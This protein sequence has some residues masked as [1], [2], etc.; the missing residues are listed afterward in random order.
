MIRFL[1]STQYK[2]KRHMKRNYNKL[3]CKLIG[4]NQLEEATYL[5][6]AHLEVRKGD[7]TM[8]LAFCVACEKG[9]L[10]FAQWLYEIK[11]TRD[12]SKLTY[13]EAFRWSCMNGD[14]LAAQWL[15]Q[16]R[17]ALNEYGNENIFNNICAY[18][19][20]QV[21]QWMYQIK[22]TI[23]IS[24]DNEQAFR[25][26]CLYGHLQ[27]AQWLLDIQPTLDISADDDDAFRIAYYDGQLHIA[28]WLQS[29]CPDRYLLTIENHKMTHY[30]IMKPLQYFDETVSFKEEDNVC[31][32]CTV[33]CVAVQTA[34]KHSYC[35]ECLTNW[36]SSSHSNFACPYCREKIEKVFRIV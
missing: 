11:P 22:P 19:H 30:Q 25:S 17:P 12:F 24:A 7:T 36:L 32:I 26:A 33:N 21:A 4:W 1:Q 10:E 5:L 23:D 15:C 14:L 35:K 29:I 9:H 6:D 31:P 27:V 3:F 18:G 28:Q 2:R 34:C 16:I 13:E 8:S 20:L